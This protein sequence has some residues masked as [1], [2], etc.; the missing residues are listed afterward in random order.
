MKKGSQRLAKLL[1]SFLAILILIGVVARFVPGV[2]R[3]GF[4]Q[5]KE[6]SCK[7]DNDC[8]QLEKCL[9]N[10]GKDKN[11]ICQKITC[12]N[13][14]TQKFYTIKKRKCEMNKK[15][16]P[17]IRE[18]QCE[19]NQQCERFISPTAGQDFYCANK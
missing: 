13:I 9:S 11:K 14:L 7:N 1:L 15:C 16:N 18:K 12:G 19:N 6:V 2:L 8:S 10:S 4:W 3:E 5:A 17:Y